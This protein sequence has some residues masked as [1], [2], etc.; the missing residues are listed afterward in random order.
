MYKASLLK[1]ADLAIEEPVKINDDLSLM[2]IKYQGNPLFLNIHGV[3]ASNVFPPNEK[4]NSPHAFNL[5]PDQEDVPNLA[6]LEE[7]LEQQEIVQHVTLHKSF[8]KDYKLNI[9]LKKG[10]DGNW[11]FTSNINPFVPEELIKQNTQLSVTVK[12]GF[13]ISKEKYGLYFTLDNITFDV[14]KPSAIQPVTLK[15]GTKKRHSQA[16]AS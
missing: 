11:V 2:E 8:G 4:Y 10:K 9:K 16:V 13:Y 1:F 5:K 7:M 12:P 3:A 6:G 14:S 15:I